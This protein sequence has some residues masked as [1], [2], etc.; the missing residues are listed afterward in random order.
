M[1]IYDIYFHSYM[2]ISTI[3]CPMFPFACALISVVLLSE[4]LFSAEFLTT[5]QW[6]SVGYNNGPQYV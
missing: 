1:G 6:L 3:C 5:N 2:Y 4:K